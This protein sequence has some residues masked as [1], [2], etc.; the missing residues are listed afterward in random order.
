MRP[1]FFEGR[2]PLKKRLTVAERYDII[3]RFSASGGN[4]FVYSA[5]KASRYSSFE[6]LCIH[7]VY[8]NIRVGMYQFQIGGDGVRVTEPGGEWKLVVLLV[9][10]L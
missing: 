1:S 6:S 5:C 2:T 3:G 8:I 7:F 10:F 9:V 4:D